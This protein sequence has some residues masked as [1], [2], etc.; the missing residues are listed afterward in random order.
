M[1]IIIDERE[2]ELYEKCN[3]LINE[4]REKYKHVFLFRQVL[5]LGDILIKTDDMNFSENK[6]EKHQKITPNKDLILIERKTFSDLSAS[7]RD[8]RYSEQSHRLSYSS[9][10]PNHNI[11]YLLEGMFSQTKEKDRKTIMSCI[12]SL[13]YFKGYSVMRTANVRES[14]EWILCTADKLER[15]LSKSSSQVAIESKDIFVGSE[16]KNDFLGMECSNLSTLRSDEPTITETKSECFQE[17]SESDF[18]TC[19]PSENANEPPEYCNFVKKEKNK[20]ITPDNIGSILLCQIPSVHSVSAIAIMQKFSSFHELMNRLENDPTCL[21]EIYT[22]TNGKK[23]K[24]SKSIIQN[25]KKYLL[26]DKEKVINP[27]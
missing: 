11:I 13:N 23:R 24:I 14:A 15:E 12:T 19:S 27:H 3:T 25:I 1:K 5:P 16:I 10:L 2:H 18:K 8:G 4:N 6:K 26:P 7:I 21:D 9:G 20:N 17:I 22:E